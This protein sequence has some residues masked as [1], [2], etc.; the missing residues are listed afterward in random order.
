MYLASMIH[1]DRLFDLAT[2][3]FADSLEPGDGRFVTEAF[4]YEFI[5]SSGTVRRFV[6]DILQLKSR[7]PP[8]L[9]RFFFKDELRRAIAEACRAPTARTQELL[10]NFASRPEEFFPR[11][12]TNLLV[13]T[14]PDGALA[15]MVR[16]KSIR[17]LAEKASRRIADRLSD[18]IRAT[19]LSLAD[20]RARAAGVSLPQLV[21]PPEIMVEEFE[22]A[23]RIVSHSF[24]DGPIVLEPRHVRIDDMIGMKFVGSPEELER[25]ERGVRE[26]PDAQVVERTAHEGAYCDVQLLVD[27]QLPPAGEIIG[28]HRGRDWSPAQDRGIPPRLLEE[29]FPAYVETGERTFRCEIILT[30]FDEL[31]ESEFGRS[32]HEERILQQRSAAPYRGRIARNASFIIEYLLMLAISPAV[33]VPSLPVKM[34]GRYLEDAFSAAVWMLFGVPYRQGLT[35][36]FEPELERVMNEIGTPH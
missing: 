15:A 16:F 4:I 27:L 18:E 29:D 33:G 32:M 12:P 21:S 9:R 30:T 36:S 19:A 25:I 5:I 14:H 28:R 23:E 17:R 7:E 26:Y 20:A 31:V 11:T 6:Q 2:R 22:S 35:G 10:R 3:W 34:W 1:R 24:R 13:A 8:R